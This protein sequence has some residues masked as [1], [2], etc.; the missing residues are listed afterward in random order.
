MKTKEAKYETTESTEECSGENTNI[1]EL[2][3]NKILCALMVKTTKEEPR[4]L[5]KKRPQRGEE[6]LK[7]VLFSQF[8]MFSVV[9]V[10]E[11]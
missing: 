8:K 3:F 7:M 9:S 10:V 4:G 1:N 6:D 11:V 5:L 2:F